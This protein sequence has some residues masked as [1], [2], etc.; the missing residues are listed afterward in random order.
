M[1]LNCGCEMVS[2]IPFPCT[3]HGDL[4]TIPINIER[5]KVRTF[6]TGATRDSEEGKLDY[7]GFL[8]PHVLQRFAVYMNKN[9]TQPDG[10]TRSSDNWQQGIPKD[11]YMKSLTRHFMEVW[12]HHRDGQVGGEDMEDALCAMMF[13]V[14]G[15]LY[16]LQKEQV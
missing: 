13:N 12:M 16:E 14:Q 11:A 5:I 8:S 1:S 7:E 15:Y 6:P 10:S 4:G 9:R 2:G 3:K